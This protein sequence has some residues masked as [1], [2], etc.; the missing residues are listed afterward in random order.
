MIGRIP[1]PGESSILLPNF[2]L[3][4]TP[5]RPYTVRMEEREGRTDGLNEPDEFFGGLFKKAK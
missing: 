5:V 4:G 3:D 1:Y 2:S